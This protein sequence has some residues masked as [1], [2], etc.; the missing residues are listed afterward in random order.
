MSVSLSSK[1]PEGDGNGLEPI[2]FDLKDPNKIH[3]CISIVTGKGANTDY[4][5]GDTKTTV[6]VR[7]IEVIEDPE[8]LALAH[9]LMMRALE[10]RTGQESLPYDLE[11]EIRSA[12]PASVEDLGEDDS[13]AEDGGSGAG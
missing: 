1:L 13:E 12:F 9:R 5:T 7:R 2:V 3:V 8:D 11:E 10:R 4:E 6:R